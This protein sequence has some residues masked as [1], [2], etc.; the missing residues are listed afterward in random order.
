MRTKRPWGSGETP[1]TQRDIYRFWLWCGRKGAGRRGGQGRFG[2]SFKPTAD[3]RGDLLDM[4]SGCM[5][6]ATLLLMLNFSLVKEL[7][8]SRVVFK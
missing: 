4:V 3:T 1:A 5:G 7:K 6:T 2:G 8:R